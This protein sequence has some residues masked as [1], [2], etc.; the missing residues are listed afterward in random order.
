VTRL[1]A[2]GFVLLGALVGA[3]L[4]VFRIVLNIH[5]EPGTLDVLLGA[6]VG[7]LV[8]LGAAHVVRWAWTTRQTATTTLLGGGRTEFE[9][10]V[11]TGDYSDTRERGRRPW[12]CFAGDYDD[13]RHLRP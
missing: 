12:S 1:V 4:N 10:R 3:T 13:R 2:G 5:D 8:V 7:V 11:K 9:R 6:T